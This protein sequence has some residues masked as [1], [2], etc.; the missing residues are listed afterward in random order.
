MR[1]VVI[2]DREE[3]NETFSSYCEAYDWLTLVRVV[4]GS[5]AGIITLGTNPAQ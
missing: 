4:F 2:A 5:N 1:Y 3:Y